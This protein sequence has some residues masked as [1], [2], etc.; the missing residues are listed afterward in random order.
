MLVVCDERREQQPAWEMTRHIHVPLILFPCCPFEEDDRHFLKPPPSAI[1]LYLALLIVNY[2]F[3]LWADGS[4]Y[5]HATSHMACGTGCQ[6]PGIKQDGSGSLD[7]NRHA[8]TA[9]ARSSI[10]T[11]TNCCKYQTYRF[12]QNSWIWV[13][14]L[15]RPLH[16]NSLH[17]GVP[18]LFLPPSLSHARLF[19]RQWISWSRWQHCTTQILDLISFFS[20]L[21][22]PTSFCTLLFFLPHLGTCQ[23]VHFQRESAQPVFLLP[24][25]E[26]FLPLVSGN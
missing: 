4:Y 1:T 25:T 23:E 24:H 22:M 20:Y 13:P 12:P 16:T 17:T 5:A 3:L 21:H 11:G 14:G 15:D 26:Q 2:C 10:P 18:Y 7:P 19:V 8:A 9:H 6:T